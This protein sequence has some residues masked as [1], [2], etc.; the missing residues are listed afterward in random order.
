MFIEMPSS[1]PKDKFQQFGLLSAEVFPA[2]WSDEDLN[3]P[4]QRRQHSDRSYMAVCYRYRTCTECN[5]EFKALLANAP[6]SW[7]EWNHHPELAYKL[8][9]C[10]YTFFM[11]GLSVFESLGFCLYF[12]GGGRRPPAFSPTGKPPRTNI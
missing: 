1:F 8:E 6:D 9:R 11:N 7:R 12:I 4:L 2:P 10:L 5:E 3:D